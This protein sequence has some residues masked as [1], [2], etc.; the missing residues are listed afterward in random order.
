MISGPPGIGKT[1]VATLVAHQLGYNVVELNASDTRNAKSV[2]EQLS[3]VVLSK[4]MT[5]DGSMAKRLVIMDEVDGMGGSDRGGI[6]ELIKVIKSSKNPIICI[7]N[8]R[9]AVKIK[10]LANHCYDLRCRRPTKNQIALR[11]IAIGKSEGLDIELNAAEMLVEQVGNDIRQV[12]HS[13]QMWR[14]QSHSMKYL[15]MKDKMKTIEKD[16]VLR[17]SPFD[18]CLTILG[19]N[20]TPL[21]ERYN[22]FFIDYSLLPLMIQHNYIDSAKSGIFRQPGLDEAEMMDRLSAVTIY[23]CIHSFIHF[24]K[25]M[26]A[27]ICNM[28][29]RQQMRAVI[30]NLLEHRLED[31]INTGSYFLP[32]Q[33]C[34]YELGRLLEVSKHFLHFL[35]YEE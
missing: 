34:L 18:A 13:M 31:K 1:S 29:D 12:L 11:M 28:I 19:G 35:G 2:T 8:D 14:A 5:Q 33:R 16:K 24:Y 20:K 15:D 10:S 17:Q 3:D 25:S 21:D 23:S 6:Q 26:L 4:A 32:K 22:S 7:C 30:W 27:C 9:Q